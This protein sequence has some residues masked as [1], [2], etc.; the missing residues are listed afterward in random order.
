MS[1]LKPLTQSL[2]NKIQKEVT[3]P[4]MFFL[5]HMTGPANDLENKSSLDIDLNI[6]QGQQDVKLE[7]WSYVTK[8]HPMQAIVVAVG[9][10]IEKDV[11]A[12]DVIY[13]NHRYYPV[14]F[15]YEKCL[16]HRMQVSDLICTV[17]NVKDD[18]DDFLDVNKRPWID[19]KG[20]VKPEYQRKPMI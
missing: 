1:K 20:K 11:K 17:G 7:D 18:I 3:V 19:L 6:L 4:G 13:W 10:D 5:V 12:G 2:F 16:F 14:P 8:E 15:M 9:K